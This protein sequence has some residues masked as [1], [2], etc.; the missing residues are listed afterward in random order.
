[1]IDYSDAC[2]ICKHF[3]QWLESVPYG[4]GT[5]RIPMSECMLGYDWPTDEPCPR[6]EGFY[7]EDEVSS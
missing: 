1:M 3:E 6:R 7:K 5:T 4:Y 2:S